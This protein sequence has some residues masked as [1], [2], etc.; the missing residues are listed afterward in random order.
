MCCPGPLEWINVTFL[1]VPARAPPVQSDQELNRRS[2]AKSADVAEI[3]IAMATFAL[4]SVCV[5]ALIASGGGTPRRI[6]VSGAT[7]GNEYTG[8]YVLERLRSR[9]A[10]LAA[11][12]PSLEVQTL[13]AN[14]KAHTENRRFLDADLNRQFTA[15]GLADLDAPGYEPNRAKVIASS[16]GPTTDLC[17]DLH[18]TTA[19]MGCTLIVHGWCELGMRIAAYVH[20]RWDAACQEDAAAAAA[21]RGGAE[22][23][24]RVAADAAFRHPLRVLVHANVTREASPHL[25]TFAQAGLQIEV[26]PVPQGMVRSDVVGTTERALRLSLEYCHKVNSGQVVATPA[27]TWHRSSTP[28][29]HNNNRVCRNQCVSA[30]PP[31]NSSRPCTHMGAGA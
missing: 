14:P 27:A 21:L 10:E 22:G 25:C 26:G 23:V 9:R 18:T 5:S 24:A 7:H 17:I 15:E 6:I 12:Y 16:L 4:L 8:P 13:L 19:N 11:L 20:T 1:T 31:F 28:L 2:R 29:F 30:G 3:P